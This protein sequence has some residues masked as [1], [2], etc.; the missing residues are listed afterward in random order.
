MDV[1]GGVGLEFRP[2]ETFE[3]SGMDRLVKVPSSLFI[4]FVRCLLFGFC[5][6]RISAESLMGRAIRA[7]RNSP[8]IPFLASRFHRHG[9][10]RYGLWGHLD[11][12]NQAFHRA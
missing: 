4:L 11:V 1:G 10:V 5:L 3:S 9:Y 7:A 6:T 8:I 2:A 12:Q